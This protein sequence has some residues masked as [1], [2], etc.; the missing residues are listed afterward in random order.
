MD[1]ER[2]KELSGIEVSSEIDPAVADAL[3]EVLDEYEGWNPYDV[4]WVDEVC[5]QLMGVN[6]GKQ[7]RRRSGKKAG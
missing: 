4:K 2:Q 6:G 3:L 5:V 7:G 1:P